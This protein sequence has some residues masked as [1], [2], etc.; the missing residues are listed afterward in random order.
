M[1]IKSEIIY[2]DNEW[3]IVNKAAGVPTVADRQKKSNN[4]L[5][6]WLNQQFDPVLPV[7]RLDTNTS[8]LLCFARTL[9]EQRRLSM[10]FEQ[11]Q[12]IKKYKALVSG[13]PAHETGTID[14]PILR[15]ENKNQV[16]ISS[17]GKAAITHYEVESRFKGFSLLDIRIETGRTHQIRIHLQHLGHPLIVDPVYGGL[18]HFYLSSVKAAY[19]QADH[20]E[21]PLL[22]RTPLH[23]YNLTLPTP[24]GELKTFTTDM[25]KDMLAVINQLGK[26]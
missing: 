6:R 17:R 26:L 5:L 2:F 10:V 3:I 7:H 4:Y 24:E 23:A 11:R 14:A 18:E 13:C 16:I 12:V 20:D 25:P 21:R 1:K 8:G 15:L 22:S 9:E 19:R